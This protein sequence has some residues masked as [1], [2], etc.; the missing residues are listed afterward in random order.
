MYYLQPALGEFLLMI[1]PRLLLINLILILLLI[2]NI[3]GANEVTINFNIN[4][5]INFLNI[6]PF[7]M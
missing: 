5:I 1:C 4:T 6:R 7:D 2:F 3:G